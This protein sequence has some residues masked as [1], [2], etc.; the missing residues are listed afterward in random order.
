MPKKMWRRDEA[1]KWEA[2]ED[3]VDNRQ[4]RCADPGS[5]ADVQSYASDDEQCCSEIGQSWYAGKLVTPSLNGLMCR[6][7]LAPH[8]VQ[9]TS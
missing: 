2:R 3:A 7:E 5:S 8:Q 1:R 9:D 4:E 6:L